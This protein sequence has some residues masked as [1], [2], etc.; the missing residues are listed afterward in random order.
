[1]SSN[2]SYIILEECLILRLTPELATLPFSCGDSEGDKDLDDFFHNQALPFSQEKLGQTYCVI[3]NNGEEA[4]LVAFFTLSNDSIKTTFIPK[5]S[6]NKIERKIPGR[7]HL[8]T[9]PA[10]LIGRLGVNKK[11]QGPKY[12]IGQQI[13]NYIKVWF[14]EEDNKTGCRFL[15]VDAYNKENVLNFYERNKFKYLYADEDT[16]RQEQHIPEDAETIY[17]RHMF[18]DLMHTEILLMPDK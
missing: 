17:T 8:H 18:L 3:D 15:V 13:L 7:K 16:E 14:T 6:V 1:M 12:F 9:Y 5:K 4:E 10:V 2:F 11:Y